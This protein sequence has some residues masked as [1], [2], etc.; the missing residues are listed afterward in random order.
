MPN[1]FVAI[2]IEVKLRINIFFDVL[3]KRKKSLI[4]FRKNKDIKRIT[5]D[6]KP[7]CIATSNEGIFFISLKNSG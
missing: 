1:H 5:K 7:L 4:L 3:N 2:K 6:Q